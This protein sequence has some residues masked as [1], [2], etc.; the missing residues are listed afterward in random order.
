MAHTTTAKGGHPMH[1]PDR[2]RALLE[3]ALAEIERTVR[4][5]QAATSEALLL[6]KADKMRS[7]WKGL[8]KEAKRKNGKA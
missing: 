8:V 1:T 4:V 7:L 2:E 6:E 3:Q 5:A